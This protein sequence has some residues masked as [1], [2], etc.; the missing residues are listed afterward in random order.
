MCSGMCRNPTGITKISD[1]RLNRM[2]SVEFDDTLFND[3]LLHR[4]SPTASLAVTAEL[5]LTK[6]SVITILAVTRTTVVQMGRCVASSFSFL[7]S[8]YHNY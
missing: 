5:L 8:S 4:N 2:S 7:F 6:K 3:G 1:R